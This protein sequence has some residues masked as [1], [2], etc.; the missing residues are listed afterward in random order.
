M[1]TQ[2]VPIIPHSLLYIINYLKYFNTLDERGALFRFHFTLTKKK[3]EKEGEEGPL[4]AYMPTLLS[5]G[6]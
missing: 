2:V 3:R 6:L 1:R 5:T 4:S